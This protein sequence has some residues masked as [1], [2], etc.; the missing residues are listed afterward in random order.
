MT[1]L[2]TESFEQLVLHKLVNSSLN[3]ALMKQEKKSCNAGKV[4]E[5]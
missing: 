2:E 1:N 3:K 5:S 4:N